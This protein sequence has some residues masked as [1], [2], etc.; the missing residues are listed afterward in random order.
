MPNQKEW[1]NDLPPAFIEWLKDRRV[2]DVECIIA[3]IAGMSRG[4]AMPAKKFARA[5][6]MY[7][8]V[9]IYFQTINGDYADL[10][11]ME[12]QWIESDLVL[13]PDLSAA[14]AVPWS[15]DVTLQV[16]HD[17][18]Y[19][20]GSPVPFS[21]RNLLK[22][23]VAKYAALDLKPV[24]AP[25]LEFF[26]TKPNT[27][28]TYP[29]EPPIGRTGRQGVARQAYSISAVEEYGPVIDDI[30]DFAEAQGFEIDTIIQESGAGQIEINLH[31]GDPIALAD[32]VF[33]YKRSIR[34][35]A[36]KNDCFATFMAKPMQNQPGSAMHIHQSVISTKTGKNIFN[37]EN[38]QPSEK[39]YGFIAGQQT[40]LPAV[41]CILAPY[42]NSYRRFVRD[43]AA[44]INLE[45]GYDNRTTGL[46]VPVSTP[47]SR[48][49]ENRLVGMDCNPYLAIAASL[50]CG[51]LGMQERLQPRE[52]LASDAYSLPHALPRG[53]HES[54]DLFHACQPIQQVLGKEFC[55][56]YSAIKTHESEAFLEVISPW[57]REHL[58]LNV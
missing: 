19:Q 11:E 45:W 58:L 2:D 52:V 46:R 54:L 10:D 40:Y 8:P 31:H 29:V 26:L 50:A 34:E 21:P 7:L 22:A 33:F 5:D 37:D 38:D 20:D 25:E 47:Q 1:I 4:K 13:T 12:N 23:I 44:P 51:L 18:Y 41:F 15:D 48:R 16:I 36:L 32:Q 3:D 28:P 49:I 17:A 56:L 6:A 9:S 39:F 27:D 42:V 53:L 35:A 55:S 43:D 57:E 24:V 30:Y 14:T